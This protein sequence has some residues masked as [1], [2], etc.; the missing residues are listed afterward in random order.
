[1]WQRKVDYIEVFKYHQIFKCISETTKYIE[2]GQLP[3]VHWNVSENELCFCGEKK[4]FIFSYYSFRFRFSTR[5]LCCVYLC[6]T[7]FV[8][9]LFAV[10]INSSLLEC[11]ERIAKKAT[12][13]TSS[14][15]KCNNRE[16]SLCVFVLFSEKFIIG[17]C[18][19]VKNM[20]IHTKKNWRRSENMLV[21]NGDKK[22]ISYIMQK[23][24]SQWHN[25]SSCAI[26]LL[27]LLRSVLIIIDLFCLFTFRLF[28]V[29]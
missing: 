4:A 11:D 17:I 16:F 1:M 29:V 21:N 24:N 9:V 15:S 25:W 10:N 28:N 12:T 6:L 7:W 22:N 18:L 14:N 8:V 5:K 3:S 23:N 20:N 26:F 19:D 27:A 13:A 2:S